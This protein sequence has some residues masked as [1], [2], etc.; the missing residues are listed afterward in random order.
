ME[1]MNIEPQSPR[2]QRNVAG[3]TLIEL[4]VVIAIIAILAG[5]LLPA[6]SKAKAAAQKIQCLNHLRQLGLAWTMYVDDNDGNVP[7]ASDPRQGRPPARF[8]PIVPA[9]VRGLMNFDGNNPSNWDV[10]VDIRTS[11]L[12]DYLHSDGVFKCPGDRSTVR[13]S[14]G[15]VLP[16]VR[17]VAMSLHIGEWGWKRRMDEDGYRCYQ[18]LSDFVDPGPS[19]TWL[20]MDVREDSIDLGNFHVWMRGYPENPAMTSFVD[21]PASYHNGNGALA[22]VDGHAESR[23]WVDPA[24]TQPI[25]KNEILPDDNPVTAHNPDI[26]WLQERTSR[27]V[28][29]AF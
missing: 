23:R 3:F 6:L 12:W 21:Y 5:M 17:S 29:D 10:T 16:R 13:T 27:R 24:T 15:Q 22:F 28:A 25:V 9:W 14:F 1:K 4:L 11:R 20:F 2:P 8:P 19:S 26:I 7:A 18:N